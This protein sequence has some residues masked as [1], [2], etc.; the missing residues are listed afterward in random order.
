MFFREKYWGTQQMTN[1]AIPTLIE[2][3][4][5]FCFTTNSKIDLLWF[6]IWFTWKS[7][8]T[9]TFL[10]LNWIICSTPWYKWLEETGF[11]LITIA[12]KTRH[13]PLHVSRGFE[14]LYDTKPWKDPRGR[15]NH[16]GSLMKRATRASSLGTDLI[17]CSSYILDLTKQASKY[18][19]WLWL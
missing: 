12:F 11:F 6:N 1:Q 14:A 10:P 18:S 8:I 7:G 13:K 2:P 3:S 4:I 15:S 16:G 17:L 19:P 5:L 9:L